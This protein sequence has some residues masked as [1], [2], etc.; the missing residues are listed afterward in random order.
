M[1]H[2]Y[3]STKYNHFV[4][5]LISII[6]FL[7]LISCS[8]GSV[9]INNKDSGSAS[10]NSK[11]DT[12][13]ADSKPLFSLKESYTIKA[14]VNKTLDQE[15]EIKNPN[16]M[17]IIFEDFILQ[18]NPNHLSILENDCVINQKKTNSCKIKLKYSPT[19]DENSSAILI[20]TYKYPSFP[21]TF[22]ELL[23]ILYSST[24]ADTS[25][26]NNNNNNSTNNGNINNNTIINNQT[27]NNT[28]NNNWYDPRK[29][30]Y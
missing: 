22:T 7:F 24:P 16:S 28:N 11:S 1:I 29:V 17:P 12:K 30:D 18:K 26:I 6:G 10:Q 2:Q 9:G 19:Q 25:I 4:C 13:P 27:T 23:T 21:E 20:V 15:I 8:K 14:Q 5:S 3:F